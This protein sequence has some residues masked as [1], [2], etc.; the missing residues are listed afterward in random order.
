MSEGQQART[1]IELADVAAMSARGDTQAR[2]HGALIEHDCTAS[3]REHEAGTVCL[4]GHSLDIAAVVA[5]A[6]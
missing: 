6:R 2:T 5:V 4:D 3:E 1:E